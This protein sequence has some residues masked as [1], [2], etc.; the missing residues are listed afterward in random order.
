MSNNRQLQRG[1]WEAL[2]SYFKRPDRNTLITNQEPTK[3][4]AASKKYNRLED[5]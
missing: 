4:A 2:A 5:V 3:A 1:E